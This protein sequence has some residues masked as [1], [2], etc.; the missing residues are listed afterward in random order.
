MRPLRCLPYLGERGRD[1][2]GPVVGPPGD[3]YNGENPEEER[4]AV[5]GQQSQRALQ[6]S[7]HSP[8]SVNQCESV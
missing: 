5:F 8:I 1:L 3:H 7:Y 4:V 6:P 2:L